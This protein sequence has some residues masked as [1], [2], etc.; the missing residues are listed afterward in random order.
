MAVS[1]LIENKAS[2]TPWDVVCITPGTPASALCMLGGTH[3]R[4]IDRTM[5]LL[6]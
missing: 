1:Y 3:E 6:V 5:L 2:I 4:S